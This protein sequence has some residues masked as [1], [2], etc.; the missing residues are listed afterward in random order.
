MDQWQRL[1][2]T[3]LTQE[4]P[5]SPADQAFM[6]TVQTKIRID[7]ALLQKA[8]QH[9]KGYHGKVTEDMDTAYYQHAL[10]VAR[11]VMGYTRDPDTLLAALMHNII[12]QTHCS[13]H[14][15][16]LCFNPVVQRII[17]GAAC[18]DSRLSSFKKI[19]LSAH[20]IMLKLLDVKDD[21]VLYVKLADRLHH[22]RTSEGHASLAKQ[23]NI[24]EETLRFFVPMAKSLGLMPIAE[25]LKK[26]CFEV[27]QNKQQ[28]PNP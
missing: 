27:F 1:P 13:L 28:Q 18:V 20:E 24:A 3:A 10:A 25:E 5:L 11:I 12:D 7:T 26:R 21:R 22:M 16:A 2:D 23:K 4:Y 9:M 8:L 17:D 6:R 15:I 14:Q 19:Q